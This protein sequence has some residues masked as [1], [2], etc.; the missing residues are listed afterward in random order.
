MTAP[1]TPDRLPDLARLFGTNKTTGGCYCMWFL[2]PAKVCSAGWSGG[3]KVAFEEMTAA[4]PHPTGLLA[5]RNGDPVGWCAVGPR[6][7]YARALR[8]PVLAGRDRDADS[9]VWL[10]CLLYTSPSPRD[11]LLSRMP[12]SA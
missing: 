1:V 9:D 3:N 2:V 6:T 10:L 8:S 12:S 5:Y 11:G 4:D 7:R